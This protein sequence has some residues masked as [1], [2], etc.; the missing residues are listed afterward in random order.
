MV[1]VFYSPEYVGAA[2]VFDTTRK[3]KWVADSLI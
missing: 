2:H 3:A 1:G